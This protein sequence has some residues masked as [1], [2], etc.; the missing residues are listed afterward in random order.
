MIIKSKGM[1]RRRPIGPKTLR[2]WRRLIADG[3]GDYRYP[4]SYRAH[5]KP[6][7]RHVLSKQAEATLYDLE[8][9]L[10]HEQPELGP[11]LS[12]AIREMVAALLLAE[13]RYADATDWLWDAIHHP[14][15]APRI[16]RHL[17]FI[18]DKS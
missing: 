15:E 4:A 9:A 18:Q 5:A 7:C 16:A 13:R 2:L 14:D 1:P 17:R 10:R 12:S 11:E 6:G 8:L 3:G